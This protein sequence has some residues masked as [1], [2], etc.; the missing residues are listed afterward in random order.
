M[1]YFDHNATTPLDERV[2]EAMKPYLSVFFGNPSS[3]YRYGRTARSAVETAREQV[4]ALAG[5][6]P[7]QVVFTSGGTEANNL[8]IKGA[9][10]M[11]TPGKI[12][13]SAIEHPSVLETAMS[14]QR[15]GWMFEAIG[16]DKNGLVT[17]EALQK[18]CSSGVDLVSVMTANNETGTIQD[19]AAMAET[20]ADKNVL[21]HTDAVQAAGKIPIDF[22]AM[23]VQMMTLSSHKING[24][25]GAGALIVDNKVGLSPLITGGGQEKGLRAG[26]ENVA[27]V[28]GFGKAA[29]IALNEMESSN[30]RLRGLRSRLE[31]GLSHIPGLIVFALN[32]ER[33]PNTV[34]FGM[35]ETDGEMLLMRLDQKGFAV[36]SGSAC[37]SGGSE[38]SHVLT[39][40]GVDEKLAKSAIRVSLGKSNTEA[41]IDS[42]VQ[43]LKT[44]ISPPLEEFVF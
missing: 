17:L 16:V 12:A 29:E 14:L 25:K 1:V 15:L 20:L 42:F 32:V 44:L 4:A 28:V 5:A 27:A 35:P 10:A 38:P 23:G 9:S 36:S 3:L 34:Q 43:V 22:K 33:L 11:L 31:A 24:P 8:A 37:S 7:S 40:M 39:A 21:L 30:S 6:S 2:L 18:A 13:V 41:E 19:I 26:T